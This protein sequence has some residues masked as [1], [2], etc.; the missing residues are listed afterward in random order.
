MFLSKKIIKKNCFVAAKS[1]WEGVSGSAAVS[2]TFKTHG[3][4][5]VGIAVQVPSVP[6]VTYLYLSEMFSL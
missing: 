6:Q 3:C 5:L 4:R 1:V 2:L